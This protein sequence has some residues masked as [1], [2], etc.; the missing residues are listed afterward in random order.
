MHFWLTFYRFF[1]HFWIIFGWFWILFV[2]VV[3]C[4][5]LVCWLVW[6]FVVGQT[7]HWITDPRHGGGLARR[8]IRYISAALG[9]ACWTLLP[10]S[11]KFLFKISKILLD[12][13]LPCRPFSGTSGNLRESFFYFG[14]MLA[15]VGSM[16]ALCWSI[17]AYYFLLL[18]WHRFFFHFGSILEPNMAP[19]MVQKSIKNQS[20]N[21]S[22]FWM[23]FGSIFDHFGLHFGSQNR[24][25]IDQNLMFN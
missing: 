3:G 14:P 25:K 11:S 20:K 8:A 10:S 17:L 22:I 24:S 18:C 6:L 1:D 7:A 5:S 19:K 21:S 12:S 13:L 4:L 9:W 15:Y 2:L 16:L 23:L